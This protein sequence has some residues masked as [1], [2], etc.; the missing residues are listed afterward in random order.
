MLNKKTLEIDVANY[1][2]FEGTSKKT[3]KTYKCIKIQGTTPHMGTAGPNR[4]GTN[5][6]IEI[7]E[8]YTEDFD[9]FY[10]KNK[11]VTKMT[12]EGIFQDGKFNLLAILDVTF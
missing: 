3:G 9:I 2:V 10:S 4:R 12:V 5:D 6:T 8:N 1:D 7:F 11:T